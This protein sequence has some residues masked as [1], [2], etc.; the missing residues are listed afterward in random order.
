MKYFLGLIACIGLIVLVFVLVL[1]G[2]SGKSEPQERAKLTDYANTSS[3]MQMTIDGPIIAEQDHVA[4]SIAVSRDE[5]RIDILKGYEYATLESK[6]F[7]NNQESYQ[8]FLRALDLAGFTMGNKDSTNKDERG[9]CAG[10]NR[11]IFEIKNGSSDVQRLWSATCKGA[12]TFKGNTAEV[13]RLFDSQIPRA[14]FS[15]LVGKINL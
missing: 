3:S 9:Q 15:K 13:R 10:G 12:G 11:F 4:Y 14:D 6:T 1:K 8:N 5:T 2:F 7:T